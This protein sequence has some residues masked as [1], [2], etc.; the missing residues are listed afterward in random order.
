MTRSTPPTSSARSDLVD[1]VP[2]STLARVITSAES[3]A[4]LEQVDLAEAR[5]ALARLQGPARGTPAEVA[6]V[7][8]EVAP[9]LVNNLLATTQ[10]DLRSLVMRT[11]TGAGTDPGMNAFTREVIAGG[12]TQRGLYDAALLDSPESLARAHQY[13]V[14]GEE[15]RVIDKAPTEFCVFGDEAVVCVER[16]GDPASDYVLIRDPMLIS[17]FTTTFEQAW[18]HSFP[19]PTERGAPDE[20]DEQLLNLLGRGLKD[21]AIARYL[22]WSLRTVRRRVARLMED[23]GART[24]F[25]L[26]AE[27]VRAGRLGL[28]VAR[29]HPASSAPSRAG[30][31]QAARLGPAELSR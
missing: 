13:R 21:E 1:E 28:P 16:W 10:G 24:R 15:Q 20:G 12:R 18:A 5:H 17:M 6:R 22:G 26:G 9:S 8:L 14:A 30:P 4:R 2:R 3:R 23:L 29:V 31:A 7:T 11:D 19:F 25:Q 27:A